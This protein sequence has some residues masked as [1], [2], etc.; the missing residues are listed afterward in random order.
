MRAGLRAHA[1]AAGWRAATV[2]S[3]KAEADM[4]SAQTLA[5]FISW[6]AAQCPAEKYGLILWDHGGGFTGFGMEELEIQEISQGVADS[7]V[8]LDMIGFMACL[9]GQTEVAYELKDVA[10]VFVASNFIFNHPKGISGGIAALRSS[11]STT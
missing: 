5:D 1:P 2:E 6:G 7:G 11:L 8:H 9:M 10:D 3:K 4:G